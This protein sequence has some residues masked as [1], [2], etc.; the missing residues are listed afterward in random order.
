MG[1]APL[2][3][4][5]VSASALHSQHVLHIHELTLTLSPQCTTSHS[6]S[7]RRLTKLPSPQYCV[8]RRSHN[9]LLPAF[10]LSRWIVYL[11]RL[12]SVPERCHCTSRRAHWTDCETA[13]ERSYLSVAAYHFHRNYTLRR[14]RLSARTRLFLHSH[15]QITIVRTRTHI[16]A[17]QRSRQQSHDAIYSLT[18]I[19]HVSAVCRHCSHCRHRSNKN[20]TFKPVKSHGASSTKRHK[21]SE[22]AK[23]TLG[24]GNMRQAVVLPKGEDVN[25]WLAVNTVDFFNE[26]SL[27]YGTITEFCLPTTCPVMCAGPNYQYL[28]ADTTGKYKQPVKVSAPE[29]VDLVSCTQHTMRSSARHKLLCMCADS[30]STPHLP[31]AVRVQLMSWVEA[32]LNDETLFPLQLGTPF[33]KNFQSVVKNIFKRLFRVYAHIYHSHFQKIVGLGAEA[34]LN[35]CFK[36]VRRMGTISH[37]Q[38]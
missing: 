32:Q 5:R 18:V 12:Q 1:C 26:I 35:T 27:L 15:A 17:T 31:Y 16:N 19:P 29:Y 37:M 7:C 8:P 14:R 21:L 13:P 34:H 4:P 38:A 24:S 30:V 28:W 25:E 10:L 20:K 9:S 11:N 6:S 22:Y 33:P 36:H 23:A 2:T 3:L